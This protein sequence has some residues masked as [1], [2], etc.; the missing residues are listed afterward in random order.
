MGRITTRKK[1]PTRKEQSKALTIEQHAALRL[2]R[3]EKLYHKT[4][5]AEVDAYEKWRECVTQRQ[6]AHKLLLEARE[7]VRKDKSRSH[8]DQDLD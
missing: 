7:N 4:V 1:K 6:E 3:L 5:V 8:A 2:A